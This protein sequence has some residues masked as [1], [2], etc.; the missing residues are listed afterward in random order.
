MNRIDMRFFYSALPNF[1]VSFRLFYCDIQKLQN[2]TSEKYI[3]E[4]VESCLFVTFV[5]AILYKLLDA[6]S[7]EHKSYFLLRVSLFIITTYS[8]SLAS[9]WTLSL[10]LSFFL[11]H[12]LAHPLS[13]SLSLSHCN[14]LTGTFTTFSRIDKLIM[15]VLYSSRTSTVLA[16]SV[17]VVIV[18][19]LRIHQS[20]IDQSWMTDRWPLFILYTTGPC[21]DIKFETKS[22][23]LTISTIF[24]SLVIFLD[25]FGFYTPLYERTQ[26]NLLHIHTHCNLPVPL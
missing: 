4:W 13:L 7:T 18:A 23:V 19:F 16:V 17:S 12:T 25:F 15:N 6:F 2:A 22:S 8:T 26:E 1:C 11:S 9:I 14:P 20:T 21:N 3:Y 10:S 24:C 5:Y